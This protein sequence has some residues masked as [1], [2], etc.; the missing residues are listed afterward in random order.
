M[1]AARMAG[2]AQQM[3]D[4]GRS[5]SVAGAKALIDKMEN[6]FERA[7]NAINRIMEQFDSS[8]E[9]PQS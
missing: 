8:H 9:Q 6:E 5:S 4:L 1:G 7:K 3:E 2:I